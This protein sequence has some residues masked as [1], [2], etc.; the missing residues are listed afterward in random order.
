[1]A[2]PKRDKPTDYA[3]SSDEERVVVAQYALALIGKWRWF[4][5][6]ELVRKRDEQALI[7]ALLFGLYIARKRGKKITKGEACDVMGVDRATTGPKF[8]RALED[9]DLIE[10]NTYAEIDRRKEFLTP[11]LKLERLVEGEVDR[12]ARN[13]K[14]LADD[15]SALDMIAGLD[16]E[17]MTRVPAGAPSAN[18]LL[19]LDWPPDDVGTPFPSARPRRKS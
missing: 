15:L 13:L 17:E 19:P 6:L 7:P 10:I 12:F 1:M 5:G 3:S 8:I 11:T 14:R 4:P 16:M 2:M 9:D 18:N